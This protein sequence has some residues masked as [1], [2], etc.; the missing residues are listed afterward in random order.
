MPETKGHAVSIFMFVYADLAGD[1]FTSRSQTGVLIFINKPPIYWYNNRQAN[2]EAST[3]ESEFCDMK[4]GVQMVEYLR[5]KLLL[6]GLPIDGSANVFC[7][8]KVVYNKTTTTG[9]VL[10]KNNNYIF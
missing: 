8:N 1:K 6:F 7:D 5:K 4:A 9:S 2:I 10:H 3:F